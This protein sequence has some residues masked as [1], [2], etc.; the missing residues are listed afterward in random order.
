MRNHAD[1]E[2]GAQEMATRRTVGVG[3]GGGVGFTTGNPEVNAE[4]PGPKGFAPAS[5]IHVMPEIGYFLR[6]KLLLSVQLRLQIIT[7]TTDLVLPPGTPDCGSDHICSAAKSAKFKPAMP[8]P[9]T[10]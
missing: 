2:P 4:V 1:A 10:R 5:T 3:I 8:D 7:T 6:E 9:I